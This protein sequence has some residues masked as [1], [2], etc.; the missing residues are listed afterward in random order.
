MERIDDNAA[1]TAQRLRSEHPE[2]ARV[3]AGF[4]LNLRQGVLLAWTELMGMANNHPDPGQREAGAQLRDGLAPWFGE[5]G[6]PSAEPGAVLQWLL[7]LPD[8]EGQ[9]LRARL[10]AVMKHL[11]TT[12]VG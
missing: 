11:R 5:H 3:A 4:A 12:P 1:D 9:L 7:Q 8:G 10:G 6:A 2:A